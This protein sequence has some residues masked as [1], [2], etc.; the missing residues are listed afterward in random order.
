MQ[1]SPCSPVGNTS[2]ASFHIWNATPRIGRPT[3]PAFFSPCNGL[4]QA[5][6]LV[7]LRPY[8]SSSGMPTFSL[9]ALSTS[10]GNGAAP[11]T[12]TRNAM[13]GGICTLASAR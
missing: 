1:I 12:Q 5:T 2:P 13:P 10:S 11:L 3:E 7:S 9:N 8:P 6:G 4:K